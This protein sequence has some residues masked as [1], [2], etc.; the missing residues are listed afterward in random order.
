MKDN[1]SQEELEQ[2]QKEQE[3]QIYGVEKDVTGWQFSRREFLAAAA[4]AAAAVTAAGVA[5]TGGASEKSPKEAGVAGDSIPLTLTLPAVAAVSPGAAFTQVW[6]L[7]NHSDTILCQGAE[8]QLVNKE[9]V[10]MPAPVSVPDIVPGGTVAVEVELVAPDAPGIYEGE[11][12]L[13]CAD[14]ALPFASGTFV[15]LNGCI[16]ESAH[17]Y[18][19]GTNQTWEITNPDTN[20]QSTRVHFSR[21]EVESIYDHIY[22]KDGD[23]GLCQTITGNYPSGLWSNSIPGTV[24]QVQ[25]SSDS[26]VSGWGFCIDQVATV[27][28]V[29][30]PIVSKQPTPTPSP[31]PRPTAT[32]CSCDI[33]ICTCDAVHYWYPC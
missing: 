27:H 17:P 5:A 21:L 28:V 24:V 18:A 33:V 3:P 30:L 2:D 8:L 19:D 10:P 15:L 23:G 4:T 6:H 14:N 13:W 16:A 29:Y 31:T 7:T 9:Q 11:W 32:P 12:H 20:A 26:S 22:L 25:L 1:E